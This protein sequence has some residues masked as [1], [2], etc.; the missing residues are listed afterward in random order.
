MMDS[1]K[2]DC[3][4]IPMKR[5]ITV[6]GRAQQEGA[7]QVRKLEQHA[8]AETLNGHSDKTGN[9]PVSRR[10]RIAA[11]ARSHPKE[12]FNNLAHHLDYELV[13]ECLAKIR[14]GSSPGVNGMTVDQARKNLSWILPPLLNQ[15][16]QGRYEAPP[17]RRV[18]VPKADGKKRPIGV[19]EVIDRAI[20]AGVSRILNE[21]YEQDFLKCSFGFRPNLGC[22]HALATINELLFKE[23]LN[24]ALEVDIRDFFG[25]LDHE[26]L[27]KFLSLRIGDRRILKLIDAWL[28]AGVM[29]K[30]KWR[31]MITGTPQG[32]SVSPILANVYLHYVLDLWFEKKIKSQLQGRAHLVRYCDDFVILFKEQE[33]LEVVRCLLKTRLA[34][35]GLVIAEEKTHVT[36]LTPQDIGVVRFVDA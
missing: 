10:A 23:K 33:D 27:R 9:D 15:I 20:Q 11:R 17:V 6:E 25:S 16:H 12:Q 22:H 4:I 35:F 3:G 36:D 13:E 28:K 29:E 24:F 5:L 19:P 2:S 8:V 18:Y 26:W 1:G 7:V 32:G 14:Y 21:I 31:E 34:Q 30:G